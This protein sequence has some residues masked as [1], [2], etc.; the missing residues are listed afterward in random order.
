MPTPAAKNLAINPS[1]ETASGTVTVRTNLASD[2]CATAYHSTANFIGYRT[3]RWAGTAP[4]AATYTLVTGASDGPLP[5]ITTYARKTWTVAPAAIANSADTG[6]DHTIS[7][8]S[9][10]PV[11]PGQI[12][13]FSSYVRGSV[14][15]NYEFSVQE[16]NGATTGSRVRGSTTFGAA[17]TWTRISFTYTVPA[18]GVT[19]IG[20]ISDSTGSTTGGA[21]KWAVGSTLDGTGLLVESGPGPVGTY[22]DGGYQSAPD[23]DFTA[24][25]TGPTNT[26]ASVLSATGL[27]NYSTGSPTNLRVMQSSQWSSNRSK[28]MRLRSYFA[29][30]DPA[31]FT[32][33]FN[34]FTVGVTYTAIAKVRLAAPLTGSLRS[35]AMCLQVRGVGGAVVAV[36][37]APANAAGVQ[38]VSVTWV[39]TASNA[40]RLYHGGTAGSG[41]VWWDDLLIIEGPYVGPYFDGSTADNSLWDYAWTGVADASSSTQSPVPRPLV[42]PVLPDPFRMAPRRE[43]Y[44]VDLMTNRDGTIGQL[45]G[46]KE[47]SLEFSASDE[48]VLTSGGSLNLDDV[49][50]TIDWLNARCQPWATV[51]GQSWPL[52]VYLM[53]APTEQHESTGRSWDVVLKDKL[54]ILDEDW[55][56]ETYAL[57]AGQ[58]VVDAIR[59]VIADAGEANHAIS[60]DPRVLSGPLTWP[61]NT[62][63]LTIVQDLLKLLNF[64]PLWVDGW[65]S[66]IGEPFVDP[67]NRAVSMAF[68]EGLSAIHLPSFQV[69]KDVASVPN[70]LIGVS[71]SSTAGLVVTADNNDA[72]SP[73]S[74]IRRNRIIARSEDFDTTDLGTLANL[75]SRR[76]L[77]LMAPASVVEFQHAVVPLEVG[78]VVRFTSDGVS[79]AG[80]VL[81]TSVTLA[82][83]QL[84]Q[85]TIQE[86]VRVGLTVS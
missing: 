56:A 23:S 11:V 5:G 65:G 78:A 32:Q 44:R 15:R 1:M 85:T 8:T 4:A 50:Q 60:A 48:G 45:D 46:V 40:L 21:V 75:V 47:I 53:S 31:S 61:A 9:A 69:T 76:M 28:S 39:A 42:P 12:L 84:M 43:R 36:S 41:D 2:P 63:R 67:Q 83:G 80:V 17:N 58:N 72:A 3:N 82:A 81:S 19:H 24:S 29:S 49:G 27:G 14:A 22:F 33:P 37:A 71:S 34:T 57:A 74:I 6:F 79:L 66:Y 16:Y 70:R 77:E 30:T 54:S 26:S 13:T 38:D 10:L 68:E 86:V 64:A 35:E 52:G 18:S 25:W 73:Y 62:S 55:M 51:N 7:G 20:P 59:Q